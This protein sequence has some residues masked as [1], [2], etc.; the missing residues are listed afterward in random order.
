MRIAAGTLFVSMHQA[1]I[2][3]VRQRNAAAAQRHQDR[4]PAE[5]GVRVEYET[6]HP[7]QTQARQQK[8]ERAPNAMATIG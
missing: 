2:G 4:M 6:A 8:Q 1:Q 5:S 7:Q 3:Q